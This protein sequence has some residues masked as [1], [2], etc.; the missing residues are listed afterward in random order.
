MYF[1]FFSMAKQHELILTSKKFN[2]NCNMYVLIYALEKPKMVNMIVAAT[3]WREKA[4]DMRQVVSFCSFAS[5][6]FAQHLLQLW[7]F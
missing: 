3:F 4:E 7:H 6:H 1:D 5:W 2:V